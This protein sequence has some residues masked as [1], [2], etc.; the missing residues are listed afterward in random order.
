MAGQPQDCVLTRKF[1][2]VSKRFFANAVPVF[3]Q[4]QT[5]CDVWEQSGENR[6]VHG[7]HLFKLF[8]TEA[9]SSSIDIMQQLQHFAQL[10]TLTIDATFM[11]LREEGLIRSKCPYREILTEEDYERLPVTKILKQFR[12]II[13]FSYNSENIFWAADREKERILWEQNVAGLADYLRRFMTQ[14][15]ARSPYQISPTYTG[16]APLYPGSRVTGVGE[17]SKLLTSAQLEDMFEPSTSEAT[18]VA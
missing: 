8:C 11:H 5:L 14:P 15:K 17:P 16:P 1:L 7:L 9:R 12:G 6:N 10:R 2:Q 3:M 13:T 18:D 4:C